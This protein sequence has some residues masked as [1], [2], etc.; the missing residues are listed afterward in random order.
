MTPVAQSIFRLPTSTLVA[1]AAAMDPEALANVM[2]S[3]ALDGDD[4]A[5]AMMPAIFGVLAPANGGA[6]A[7]VQTPARKTASTVPPKAAPAA[8]VETAAS[9]AQRVPRK[10]SSNVAL[11][12]GAKR[13]PDFLAQLMD[14][15]EA[16]VLANPGCAAEQIAKHLGQKTTK[17]APLTKKLVDTG[18]ITKTGE[19]RGTRYHAPVS[20]DS[21]MAAE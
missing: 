1:A 15:I 9:K 20:D 17:L 13:S 14:G 10:T 4:H 7:K 8:K 21:D 11:A 19:K 6:P 3:A 18:K 5:N 16:Y 12:K 2:R